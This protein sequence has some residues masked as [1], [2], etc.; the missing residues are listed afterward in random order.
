[1]GEASRAKR[2]RRTLDFD[3]RV[4]RSGATD[5]IFVAGVTLGPSKEHWAGRPKPLTVARAALE[6]AR[7]E[8]KRG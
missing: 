1:M 4:T 5:H 7:L 8:R 3:P 6:L 2:L